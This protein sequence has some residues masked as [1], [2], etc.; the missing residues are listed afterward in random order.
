MKIYRRKFFFYATDHPYYPLERKI[1]IES[2]LEH[3]L[4]PSRMDQF[5]YSTMDLLF[6]E[7]IGID[8]ACPGMKCTEPARGLADVGKIDDS[9]QDKADSFFG[10]DQLPAEIRCMRKMM[11]VP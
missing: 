10:M 6:G 8:L 11:D 1:G 3:H 9:V 2:S 5:I 7:N 4:G